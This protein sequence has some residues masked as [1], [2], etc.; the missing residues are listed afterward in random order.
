M[1]LA[2]EGAARPARHDR[3]GL[4][5]WVMAAIIIF[6]MAA[7]GPFAISLLPFSSAG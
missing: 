1:R 5:H 7:L 6:A 2:R 3:P 4:R